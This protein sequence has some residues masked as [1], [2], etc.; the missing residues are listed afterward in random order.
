[1]VLVFERRRF[2]WQR[3]NHPDTAFW[4]WKVS[5]CVCVRLFVTVG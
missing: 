3:D 4:V 2:V 5:V 1:M